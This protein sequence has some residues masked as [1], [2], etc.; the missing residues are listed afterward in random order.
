MFQVEINYPTLQEEEQIVARAGTPVGPA[1]AAVLSAPR[2]REMQEAIGA[3]HCSNY[4]VSHVAR[5]VRATR[6]GDPCAPPFVNDWVEWGAGPRA[7]QY[8]VLGGKA[9]AAMDGRATVAPADIQALALPVMRHRVAPSFQ[10]QAEGVTS[11]A[12][13]RRVL[14]ATPLPNERT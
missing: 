7:G 2:L 5:L 10:A 13:I 14:E 9:L 8:L 3:V 12:I 11:A 6:P 1:P 4:L